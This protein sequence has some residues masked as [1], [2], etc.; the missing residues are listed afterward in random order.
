MTSWFRQFCIYVT[1]IDAT[2]QFYETLGLECTS[3]T[4]ITDDITEAVIENPEKGAWIQLAQNRSHDGPIDMGSAIW[5]LY[6]YTDD[7]VGTYER[8]VAAGY[9]SVTPPHSPGRWPV[10][11]AFISDPDGYLIEIVQ[12]DETPTER[13]A[14]GTPRDQTL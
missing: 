2:V 9:E 7:C 12:R 4:V 14:G 5:K 13:N 11:M 3:R 10:T 8:A 1:D 6:V